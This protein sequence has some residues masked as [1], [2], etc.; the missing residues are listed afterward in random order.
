[1]RVKVKPLQ[2]L[3]RLLH[4][5]QVN[6]QPAS[7]GTLRVIEER[8]AELGRLV[9]RARLLDPNS[10]VAADLLP[11]L[12]DVRL[13]WMESQRLRLTGFERID[14]VNYAQTWEVEVL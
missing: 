7:V 5:L 3:G 9:L 14:K 13:L 1:M 12:S 2:K 4:R 10:G 11:D 6:T 8:D